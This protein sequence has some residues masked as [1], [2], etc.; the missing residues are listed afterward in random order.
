MAQKFL[1]TYRVTLNVYDVKTRIE[2]PSRN[3]TV[4]ASLPF[5][6][7]RKAIEEVKCEALARWADDV[8]DAFGLTAE[9]LDAML[10]RGLIREPNLVEVKVE[11]IIDLTAKAVRA[12]QKATAKA[13]VVQSAKVNAKAL[14]PYDW[15]AV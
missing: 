3:M 13:V 10:R 6:A 4:V 5:R 15:T 9:Q 11:R 7:E 1:N 14:E 2:L 12:E 8:M